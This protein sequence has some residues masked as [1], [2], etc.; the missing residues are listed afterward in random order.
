MIAKMIAIDWRALKGYYIR[1]LFIP[2]FAFYIGWLNSLLVTPVIVVMILGYSMYPFNIEDKGD[3]YRLY[4]TLPVTRKSVV[5]GRFALSLAMM[6]CAILTGI[7][8]SLVMHNFSMSKWYIGINGR[9]TVISF[10]YLLYSI[11]N[12]S[13]FPLLF[14]LGYHKGKFWG[15]YLPFIF[16]GILFALYYYIVSLSGNQELTLNLITYASDNMLLV[17]GVM[18]VL[19]TILLFLS[20]NIS[21]K[22]Y[23]K[24]DF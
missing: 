6:I 23:S 3:L 21:I 11:F 15:F 5:T 17:N 2:I 20:Y 1:F 22:Q 12:L 13:M 18:V 16:F 10:S 7:A 14:R 24:R 9:I 19:A 8:I 4:L